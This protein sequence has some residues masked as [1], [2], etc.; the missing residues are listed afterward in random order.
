MNGPLDSP[1]VAPRRRTLAC[2]GLLAAGAAMLGCGSEEE[3]SDRSVSTQAAEEITA[4]LE[5][6]DTRFTD[7]DCEGAEEALTSLREDVPDVDAN[8]TFRD[9][10]SSLLEDL[11]SQLAEECAGSEGETTS[12]T[13]STTDD[14]DSS[15]T[16][17]DTVPTDTE[18]STTEEPPSTEE[19]EPPP[20]DE[21]E[22]PVTPDPPDP[23]ADEPVIPPSTGG[24]G[25]GGSD[26]SGGV[27]PPA[28]ESGRK[29]AG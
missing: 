22:E 12:S 13:T 27:T 19:E 23:S 5:L 21:E 6:I 4:K 2:L 1:R 14:T 29:A 20:T 16:E 18:P 3:P 9:E 26:P 28:F 15:V 24:T 7:N 8:Q 10:L 17:T 25:G 11:D